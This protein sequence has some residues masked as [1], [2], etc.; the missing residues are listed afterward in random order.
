MFTARQ[1]RQAVAIMSLRYLFALLAVTLFGS[2]CATTAAPE[3]VYAA[4][5]YA[6]G[7]TP[8]YRTYHRPVYDYPAYYRHRHYCR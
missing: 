6:Y 2:A 5:Y 8:V 1:V 4:G 7:T 3:P